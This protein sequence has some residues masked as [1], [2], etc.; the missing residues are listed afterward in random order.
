MLR[1]VT[2]FLVLFTA[3]GPTPATATHDDGPGPDAQQVERLLT[4]LGAADP[5]VCEMAVDAFGNSWGW[6]DRRLAVGVLHDQHAA[7]REARRLFSNH[8]KDPQALPLLLARL[9]DPN[10][11]VRR[12]AAKLLA[13]H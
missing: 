3:V 11:C 4:A 1:L 5:L 13:R 6:S 12:A 8:V 7:A 2:L 10:P 9:G